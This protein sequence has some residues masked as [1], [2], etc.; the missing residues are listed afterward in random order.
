MSVDILGTNCDQ[1]RSM[2]QCCFT[3]TETVR[4]IRTDSPGRLP[5]LSHSSWTMWGAQDGHL[6]FHTAPE[7]RVRWESTRSRKRLARDVW[8][9]FAD[10]TRWPCLWRHRYKIAWHKMAALTVVF[11]AGWAGGYVRNGRPKRSDPLKQAGP[12]SPEQR[13]SRRRGANQWKATNVLFS[14]LFQRLWGTESQRQWQENQVL[15]TAEAK[16]CPNHYTRAQLHLP[17]HTAP[18][19]ALKTK[20]K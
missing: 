8:C 17:V 9:H 14:L 6:D 10:V 13:I 5:R 4:L 15:R 19:L 2:V 7:L 3:S 16:D 20:I 18:G 11:S 1:C 12:P